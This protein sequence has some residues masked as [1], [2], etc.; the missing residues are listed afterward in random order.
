MIE[1]PE[2]RERVVALVKETLAQA[3]ERGE[4]IHTPML[5]R[6]IARHLDGVAS[7]FDHR[8]QNARARAGRTA[9]K[10]PRDRV[11]EEPPHARA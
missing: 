8:A 9:P 2:D 3:L 4:A 1:R 11:P 6:E 7:D 5:K 10:P